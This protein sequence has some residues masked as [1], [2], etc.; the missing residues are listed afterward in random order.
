MAVRSSQRCSLAPKHMD[1]SCPLPHARTISPGRANRSANLIA[2]PRSGTRQK[3]SPSLP[4]PDPAPA[5]IS[6][7]I[8]SNDSV[9][10][11][12]AVRTDK[13]ASSAEISAIM[14]RFSL[15]RKPADPKTAITRPFPSP[16]DPLLKGEMDYLEYLARFPK[17]LS[18]HSGYAQNQQWR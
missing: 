6:S 16:S 5:A 13:S 14:R 7:R 2:S 12:S 17:P 9:R 11:S 10:G 3:V 1:C 8:P 15:S 18:G 4:P